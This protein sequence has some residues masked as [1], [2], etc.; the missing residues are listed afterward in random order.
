MFMS[1]STQQIEGIPMAKSK[2][3]GPASA[4]Y[5]MSVATDMTG[6]HAQTLRKY[7]REGL[8]E[9]ARTPGGSRR[10]SADDVG[11][12]MRIGE[13]AGDGVNVE[14]IRRVIALQDRVEELERRLA[15]LEETFSSAM[16][17]A[18]SSSRGSP[19]KKERPR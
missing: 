5:T 7:E 4:V 3:R 9:P 13:L 11:R 18:R 17:K 10:F 1:D 14:G 2:A 12:L 6:M 15:A 19:R 16:T 8:L